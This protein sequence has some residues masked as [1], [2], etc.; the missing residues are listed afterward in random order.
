MQGRPGAR[1]RATGPLP[2]LMAAS[3]L[4]AIPAS[5]SP[6]SGEAL[7]RRNRPS[8]RRAL[9]GGGP[10]ALRDSVRAGRY[11]Y[12]PTLSVGCLAAHAL[13]SPADSRLG[14]AG[15]DL[16]RYYART[17]AAGRSS[18]NDDLD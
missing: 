10:S 14:R 7:R 8:H 11:G 17:A 15:T 6:V 1:T 3:R 12:L 16:H 5:R 4:A 18:G 9:F 2:A 13:A